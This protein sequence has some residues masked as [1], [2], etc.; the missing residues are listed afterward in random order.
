MSVPRSA[1]T[2]SAAGELSV[3]IV[4]ADGIVASVPVTIVEDA[5][6]EVWVAGP[7]DGAQII[8]QGQDFVKDGQQVG[9]VDAADAPRPALISKS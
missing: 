7:E 4:G 6:D 2:F 3:R 8:V 1:L 9:A 5:R